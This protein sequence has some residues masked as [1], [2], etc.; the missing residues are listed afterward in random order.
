[1]DYNDYRPHG[2]P[3]YQAP[4]VYAEQCWNMDRTLPDKQAVEMKNMV[5]TF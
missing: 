2:S 3:D 5:E 1:M 4:A